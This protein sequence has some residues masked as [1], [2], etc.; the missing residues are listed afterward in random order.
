MRI[1][2][3]TAKAIRTELKIAYPNVKFN[4][5]SKNFAGGDAV[6]IRWDNGV[7][8]NKVDA[9]VDKYQYGHFDGM[10]DCYD[11][12]NVIADLPQVKYVCA[13]RSISDDVYLGCFEYFKATNGLFVDA[14][15]LDSWIEGPNCRA[16]CLIYRAI[17]DLDF[18]FAGDAIAQLAT[19]DE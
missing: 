2:A 10:T 11:N 5:T 19:K 13:Q 16:S 7:S 14:T 8:K 9:I 6:D 4:V 17:N 12:T 18:N 1:A 3:Q 15:N